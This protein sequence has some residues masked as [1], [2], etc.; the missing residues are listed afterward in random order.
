MGG[1]RKAPV[2][3]APV[4]GASPKNADP[5]PDFARPTAA[6]CLAAVEALQR[7]HGRV[8]RSEGRSV[9]D[10]LVRTI[11]SQNTT[12][13]TSIRAFKSLKVVSVLHACEHKVEAP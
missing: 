10:S 1:K 6:E 7:L 9:L 2:P 13:K 8:K 4:S 12:D 3:E 11:L 5:F